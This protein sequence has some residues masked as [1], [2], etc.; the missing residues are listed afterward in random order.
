M[1]ITPVI[2]YCFQYGHWIG[3]SMFDYNAN[4]DKVLST[5][6]SSCSA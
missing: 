5:E 3:F 4:G 6:K 1:I 2:R